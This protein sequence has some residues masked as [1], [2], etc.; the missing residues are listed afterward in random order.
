[1]KTGYIKKG[2]KKPFF[3]KDENR[4]TNDDWH[5]FYTLYNI[6]YNFQLVVKRFEDDRQGKHQ[7][8]AE[9]NEVEPLLS[10]KS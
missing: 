4:M 10:S 1:M 9:D 8:K 3:F 6:L 2:S 7:R 5:M